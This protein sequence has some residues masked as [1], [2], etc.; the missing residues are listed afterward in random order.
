MYSSPSKD[1]RCVEGLREKDRRKGIGEKED[2]LVLFCFFF[3]SRE[4]KVQSLK[5]QDRKRE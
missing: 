4:D 1:G 2:F 3:L 5:R